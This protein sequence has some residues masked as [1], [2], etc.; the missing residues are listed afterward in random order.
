MAWRLRLWRSWKSSSRRAMYLLRSCS[1]CSTA[2]G[3]SC[4]LHAP[5]REL[6][7]R[8]H[9]NAASHQGPTPR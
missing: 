4:N 3:F 8:Q 1:A 2:A 6:H 9:G 7:P 5:R